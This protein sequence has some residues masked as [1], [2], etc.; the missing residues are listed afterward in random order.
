MFLTVV[1]VVDCFGTVDLGSKSL[2][3][4]AIYF[5]DIPAHAGTHTPTHIATDVTKIAIQCFIIARRRVRFSVRG[6][7]IINDI[8]RG[9]IQSW[10]KTPGHNYQ[11]FTNCYVLRNCI[12]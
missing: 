3:H 4:V 11:F 2:V 9:F 7:A 5:T 1:V 8:F 6:S 10:Q 12:V